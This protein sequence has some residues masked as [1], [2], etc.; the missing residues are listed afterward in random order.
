MKDLYFEELKV[1]I[2]KSVE[3]VNYYAENKDVYRN[4]TNYGGASAL[5]SVLRDF[6]HNVELP[7]WEDEG[8]LKI[9]FLKVDEWKI[10][11]ES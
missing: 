3:N 6:G 10:E 2:F 11:K 4:H 7:V 9:P 8:Y 5:A 1:R